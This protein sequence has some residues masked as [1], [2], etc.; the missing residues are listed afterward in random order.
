MSH[1]GVSENAFPECIDQQWLNNQCSDLLNGVTCLVLHLMSHHLV[2][3]LLCE[4]TCETGASFPG[5]WSC[6]YDS[7]H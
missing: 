5:G 7:C 6:F 3:R 1:F 4:L 2:C